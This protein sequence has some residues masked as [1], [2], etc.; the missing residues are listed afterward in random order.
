MSMVAGSVTITINDDGTAAYSGT[1]YAL[2]L[3]QQIVSAR[4]AKLQARL[5]YALT[6][7]PSA[8]STSK[9]YSA[10]APA[11][12]DA[13]DQLKNTLEAI[14]D[15]AEASANAHAY[16]VTYV[17]SNAVAHVT[18]QQLGKLPASITTGTPIDAPT[19]P[20]DIPIT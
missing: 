7:L 5:G 20:V 1:G 10:A 13:I 17:T 12:A 15:D 14:Y 9:P 6:P 8:G 19:S 18:S 2:G 11:T 16:M 3:A 4:L